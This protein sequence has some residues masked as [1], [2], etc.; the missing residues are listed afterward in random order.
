MRRAMMLCAAVLCATT[1]LGAQQTSKITQESS[2]KIKDGDHVKIT[3]CIE[4]TESGFTLSNLSGN[5]DRTPYFQL[6]FD[7][8]SHRDDV[9]KY[10]GQKVELEGKAAIS[11][12]AKV[13]VKTKVKRE[14]EHGPDRKAEAKTEIKGEMA[15]PLLEVD[16]VKRVSESCPTGGQ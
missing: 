11:D 4:R 13:E 9:A 16:H 15:V 5:S 10:V 8:D 1:T 6:V 2:V 3:G 7:D 14:V 12:D